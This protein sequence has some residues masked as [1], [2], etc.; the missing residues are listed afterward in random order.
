MS[1]YDIVNIPTDTVVLEN[2]I[3]KLHFINGIAIYYDKEKT[4]RSI[5]TKY[6]NF[7][8]WLENFAKEHGLSYFPFRA[9]IKEFIE[10]VKTQLLNPFKLGTYVI[11][12]EFI[13]KLNAI[14]VD[15]N[16]TPYYTS[17][18]FRLI[19]YYLP[20]ENNMTI[21]CEDGNFLI[22]DDYYRFYNNIEISEEGLFK[23]EK[24][25]C[26]YISFDED[27]YELQYGRIC[28]YKHYY[29]IDS[30]GYRL[31]S[32]DFISFMRFLSNYKSDYLVLLDELKNSK[33][34]ITSLRY[35]T[36]DDN[37]GIN[38]IDWGKER[39][40]GLTFYC[41]EHRRAL[42]DTYTT[43]QHVRNNMGGL[44]SLNTLFIGLKMLY[45]GKKYLETLKEDYINTQINKLK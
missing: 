35:N 3:N 38:E 2:N 26:S 10:N 32:Q 41:E 34:K 8:S 40:D 14:D 45:N 13:N 30:E 39:D 20:I 5:F 22:H 37:D 33:F 44:I 24:R 6:A 1:N 23:L 31:S 42:S 4:N 27:T 29:Y 11:S 17:E 36:Y 18:L 25:E 7:N 19:W 16:A 9:L 43:T 21:V 15:S 28:T 12:K